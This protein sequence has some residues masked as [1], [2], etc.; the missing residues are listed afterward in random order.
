LGDA[1]VAPHSVDRHI[2]Q[3]SRFFGGKPSEK[4]HFDKV[5][6]FRV[7]TGQF[8]ERV[9]DP[10]HDSRLLQARMLRFIERERR[11]PASPLLRVLSA[12]VVNQD[13]SHHASRNAQEMDAVTDI[14]GGLAGQLGIHL[15]NK[16]G[17]LQS[18]ARSFTSQMFLGDAAQFSVDQWQEA[19]QGG[20]VALGVFMNKHRYGCGRRAHG[21]YL[22]NLLTLYASVSH[23]W[24]P[25]GC[26]CHES[27]APSG[28]SQSNHY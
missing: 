9:I 11:L 14:G 2:E 10:N 23:E 28:L 1:E 20:F 8:V 22:M 26:N 21:C 13:L 19:V 17:G 12:G 7:D 27:F 6:F 15:M 18:V 5:S 4:T 25:W 24:Q 16:S 3:L